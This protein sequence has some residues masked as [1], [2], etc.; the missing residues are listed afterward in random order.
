M[1]NRAAKRLEPATHRAKGKAPFVAA[2]AA[3]FIALGGSAVA[4]NKIKTKDLANGAVT[5]AKI[6]DGAV[7]NS[8]LNPSLRQTLHGTTGA[9]GSTG[10]GGANGT[11][12]T[13]GTPGA[14]GTN[15]PNGANG[16]NGANGPNGANGVDGADGT[17]GTNGTNGTNGQNGADGADGVLSPF[18]VKVASM[19]IPT[20]ASRTVIATLP[21]PQGNYIVLAKT[22]LFQTGAGDAV[23]CYL[24]AGNTEIDQVSMKTLP[25]L[26]V[27]PASLQ[28]VTTT[29]PTEIS[30]ECKVRTADGEADYTKLIAIPIG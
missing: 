3:L 21:V 13:P 4:A 23:D 18:S 17:D 5:S 29:S 11:P 7:M 10:D 8:D 20:S 14:N 1:W 27:V 25:A 15:G 2:G 6:K 9:N 12:G 22:Q 30:L 19:P 28:A 16:A 26:A 24:K